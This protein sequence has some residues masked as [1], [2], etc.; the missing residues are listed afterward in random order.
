MAAQMAARRAAMSKSPLSLQPVSTEAPKEEDDLPPVIRNEDPET[1]NS[2]DPNPMSGPVV[3]S[4][5]VLMGKMPKPEKVLKHEIVGKL[6]SSHE[7]KP[8]N[9]VLTSAGLFFSRP[10]EDI[11]RDLIPL[12]EVLDIRKRHD[13][14][15]EEAISNQRLSASDQ[16]PFH[17]QG[18]MRGMTMTS[19]IGEGASG[20]QNIIQI[21]TVES[22]YNSGRTYFL[23]IES[24]DA[25][26]DWVNQL[27]IASER[28]L[29]LKQAGPSVLH[30]LRLHI[31]T[32]YRS[33]AAQFFVA[34]LIFLSF[35]VNIVQ[36]PCDIAFPL[37]LY[38]VQILGPHSGY[39]TFL[40]AIGRFPTGKSD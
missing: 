10:D 27:R 39:R 1:E 35:V 3:V 13:S 7:W 15:N 25:C 36:V 38:R 5:D 8:M 4:S 16:K 18:S 9:M 26:N 12:F 11:L 20:S 19:L 14:P 24:A 37:P 2:Q 22:G 33:T 31:R 40:Q 32:A 30:K 17:Q 34:V 28:A 29:M 23:K 21:R 6:T